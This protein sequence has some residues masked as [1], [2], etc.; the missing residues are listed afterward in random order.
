M[1]PIIQKFLNTIAY[2][3]G[4]TDSFG[5]IKYSNAFL[6]EMLQFESFEDLEN[7]SIYEFISSCD[8]SDIRTQ[9]GG[10]LRIEEFIEEI[11]INIIR[12]DNS[13]IPVLLK[14]ALIT[15][16]VNQKDTISYSFFYIPKHKEYE[17]K[18]LQKHQTQKK[19]IFE[20]SWLNRSIIENESFCIVKTDIKGN[21]TYMNP[22]MCK[23]LGV[24][25]LDY[26][27]KHSFSLIIPEDH[28]LCLET[29]NKCIAD[30]SQIQ[31]V[32]L[33][34]PSPLG[35]IY[36]H[37]EFSL[38]SD[39]YGNLSEFLCVGHDITPIIKKQES[40]ERLVVLME[41]Q[42]KKLQNFTY[43][44]SHNIRSHVANLDGVLSVI[45]PSDSADAILGFGHL[46]T[47]IASLDETIHHLNAII[48]IQ[49]TTNLPLSKVLI[50]KEIGRVLKLVEN[51][52]RTLPIRFIIPIDDSD[53]LVTN[54]AYLESML[55]NL[56][57][58]AVKYCS[59]LRDAV[60]EIKLTSEN[61][62]KVLSIRDNGLGIDLPQH[63]ESIFG[64]YKTFHGNN[65]SR[66]LGLF[67][68]KNQI[69][70]L[71]GKVEVESIIGTG[72]TFK[73]FFPIKDNTR[74]KKII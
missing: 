64:M 63:K 59:P 26:I 50:K 28:A 72:S 53:F 39:D 60:I 5:E 25:A 21:Y 36:N 30:P 31:R 42:N 23:L 12:K 13:Q 74:L 2:G 24:K 69:E 7:R 8:A 3:Y 14:A 57:S 4:V 73:L 45:D 54:P 67:I 18:L 17:R 22:Y 38:V 20:L 43:I 19:Q 58:N 46:K 68:V 35:I 65:D 16:P 56:M 29:V 11:C 70:S 34:K 33:R 52:K 37:W 6:L 61:G 10:M 55:Y 48:V 40:L 47:S 62:F 32:V 27:G 71:K 9:I 1:E 15:N 66:G 49:S 51:P 44:I 41:E